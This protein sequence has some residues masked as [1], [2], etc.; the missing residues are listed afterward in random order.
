VEIQILTEFVYR[1]AFGLALAMACTSPAL[2]TSGYFRVHSYVLLGLA[3][4][5]ALVA[6][7]EPER[8]DRWPAL[9]AGACSYA[10]S[11]VWLYEKHRL[12]RWLLVAVAVLSFAGA[13]LAL[14][15]AMTDG[16][17]GR[18]DVW[19]QGLD[20]LASGL[21]LGFAMA[22][23]LLGHWYLN[24]PTMQLAPLKRL[25]LMLAAAVVLRAV[26]SLTGLGL[27]VNAQG[28][29]E[30]ERLAFLALRWLAGI[31]GTGG[32][33]VMTWLTLKIPNTQSATGILYVAV[34]T[35]FLGELTAQLLSGETLYPL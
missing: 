3:C 7:T 9:A 21:L 18:A 31:L 14:P 16:A 1:L 30:R 27:E 20:T 35:T 19:L 12:G 15:A 28:W 33:T 5:S 13:W 8:F 23:M 22:A 10:S 29:P 26:V 4:L 25:V 11:V 32:V 6:F 2:V 34:I 17:A 24:T